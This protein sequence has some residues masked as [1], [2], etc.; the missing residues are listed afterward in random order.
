MPHILFVCTANRFRSPIAA[1]CFRRE[2]AIRKHG[3]D[4]R[5]SSAGTWTTEEWPAAPEAI[6][7]AKRLGLDI[8][9]HAS[10]VINAGLVQDADLIVVMEHGHKE[11]LQ[12]EFPESACKVYLL[13]EIATGTAYDVPDPASS[14]ASGEIHE[15]ID[16]LIRNG[17]EHICAL[18]ATE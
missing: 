2:L 11:A 4:W 1:A 14:T 13:T 15:E 6:A 18:A 16:E 5:V 9:G 10:R 7:G 3:A 8:S 12:S 17:F